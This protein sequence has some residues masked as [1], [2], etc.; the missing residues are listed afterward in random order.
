LTR[1]AA[2][3][4]YHGV[5]P[6]GENRTRALFDI[7]TILSDN[8]LSKRL[9]DAGYFIGDLAQD[10]GV[11]S[12]PLLALGLTDQE[13]RSGRYQERI[14]LDDRPTYRALWRRVSEGWEDQLYAEYRIRDNEGFYHWIETHAVVI[15][16]ASDGGVGLIIGTDR[17]IDSRKQ[18]ELFLHEKYELAESLRRTGTVISSDLELSSSLSVGAEKLGAMVSSE[19]CDINVIDDG[20]CRRLFSLPE[21]A[22]TPPIEIDPL[23]EE[24][25][26]R[27]YPIIKD[28]LGPEAGFRSWMGVPLRTNGVFLGAVFL[29]HSTAG[30]FQGADLY[31]VTGIAEFLAVAIH[32]NQHFRRAVSELQ[33]DELTGFLT[34]R[35]FERGAKELWKGYCERHPT[36][37]IAMM[38]ID[39]FKEVNDRYGH[40]AGD[41]VIRCFARAIRDSLRH[42]DLIAR[43]GGEE[44]V[45]ILPN[46]SRAVAARVMDRVRAA[47]G[48]CRV[49]GVTEAITVSIGVAICESVEDLRDVIGRAD[50]ALYRAKRQGRNRVEIPAVS[51]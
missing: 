1:N 47:C 27:A 15:E 50:V 33:T 38:D 3:V 2:S 40:I 42:D 41:E 46:T 14:H 4:D 29:W 16:R 39:R 13:M 6:N 9:F 28:D 11:T 37:A 18:A 12:K 35:S 20:Q 23:C 31:A 43:Y 21:S 51:G 49:D 45:V 19:R 17:N 32:N 26:E 44:F 8:A 48:S 34:R 25:R 10:T 5:V 30:F 22:P 36:N 7:E 24:L